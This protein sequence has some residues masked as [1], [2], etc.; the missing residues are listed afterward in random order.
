MSARTC[1]FL[2]QRF[3]RHMLETVAAEADRLGVGALLFTDDLAR[4]RAFEPELLVVADKLEYLFQ[5]L[6]TLPFTLFTR[7][8]FASKA[9]L[10]PAM[11][12]ADVACVSSEWVRDD[13]LRQQ[14]RPRVA[15]AVTGFP[16]MDGVFAALAAQRQAGRIGGGALNV[17]YAPTFTPGYSS[18]PLFDDAW[19]D[20]VLAAAPAVRLTFKPHPVTAEVYPEALRRWHDR[21]ARDD[22]VRIVDD[23]AAD[24]YALFPDADVLISDVSSVAFYYL[25][26]N[27]PMLF[28]DPPAPETNPLQMDPSGVEWRWR[29]CAQRV[30][31]A[32]TLATA[33]QRAASGDDGLAALRERYAER[34]F[35]G[36]RDD[37]AAAR[38]ARL[39]RQLAAPAAEHTPQIRHY[40]QHARALAGLR[41]VNQ[42]P[43]PWLCQPRWY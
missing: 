28:I 15:F 35:G 4:A 6:P 9:N 2:G 36:Q 23:A 18:V 26:L 5:D 32:A 24:V 13:V 39:I 10:P 33:M 7:H 30:D 11:R 3:H 27:R 20:A 38:I 16:P 40:W 19:I 8:G 31:S 17:L 1:F 43:W 12:S 41:R 42:Q 29:D 22:R 14:I 34:V 21:A 37:Q 25:A